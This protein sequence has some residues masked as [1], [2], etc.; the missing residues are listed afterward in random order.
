MTLQTGL[1]SL[2]LT[3]DSLLSPIVRK[4]IRSQTHFALPSQSFLATI[5]FNDSNSRSACF[6]SKSNTQTVSGQ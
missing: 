3:D 5:V 2:V 4:M 1:I 6:I